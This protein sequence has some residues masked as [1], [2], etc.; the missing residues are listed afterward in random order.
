LLVAR[1]LL[2]LP[3]DNVIVALLKNNDNQHTCKG[4]IIL[5]YKYISYYLFVSVLSCYYVSELGIVNSWFFYHWI[6]SLFQSVNF[7]ENIFLHCFKSLE[8]LRKL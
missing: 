3:N 2:K 8:K 6:L 7:F 5:V 4:F 1:Q